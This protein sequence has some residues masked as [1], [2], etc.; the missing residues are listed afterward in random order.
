MKIRV[1]LIDDEKDFV[2]T[3]AERLEIRRFHVAKA[4]NGDEALEQVKNEDF[5]VIF[6]DL[7][8]PGKD[9]LQTLREIKE[10][11]PLAEVIL[12][13]GHGTPEKGIDFLQK[14]AFHYLTKPAKMKELLE[15]IVNALRR[16]SAQE[17]KIRRADI[18]R[19]LLL[20]NEADLS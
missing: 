2:E 14:G 19:I 5:D 8:M 10:I 11:R 20:L 13:T 7:K 16:K 6:L 15:A 1:L 9:S 17:E 18:E 12:L 4:F 3:L